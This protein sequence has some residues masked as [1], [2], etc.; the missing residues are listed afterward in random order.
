MFGDSWVRSGSQSE[1]V[2]DI[3]DSLAAFDVDVEGM[4]TETGPGVYETA[5]RYD[6]ALRGADKAALFKS[7]VKQ[8]AA[9]HGLVVTFMAKWNADL[10]GC[11]GHLHES[12]WDARGERNVLSDEG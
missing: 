4:H 7:A 8:I 11:S 2:H 3:V 6:E 1:L 5:I 9:R 10:P 12:L